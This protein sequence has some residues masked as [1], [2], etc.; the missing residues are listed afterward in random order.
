MEVLTS[1]TQTLVLLS[2]G[3]EDAMIPRIYPSI[4]DRFVVFIY[5]VYYCYTTS[6]ETCKDELR[7]LTVQF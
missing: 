5:I 2:M 7:I 4:R 1:N 3:V 6:A